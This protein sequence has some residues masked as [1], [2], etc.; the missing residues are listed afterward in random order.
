M[1]CKVFQLG[2]SNEDIS[3]RMSFGFV[4]LGHV[5]GCLKPF[6]LADRLYAS[7]LV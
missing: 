3:V 7:R 5:T 6:E 4:L 1:H 2:D